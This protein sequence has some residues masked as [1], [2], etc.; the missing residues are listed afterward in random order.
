MGRADRDEADRSGSALLV[1]DMQPD[2]MAGGALAVEG[3]D[4]IVEPI[5]ALMES[6]TFGI[7]AA[8]QDWHPPGH[9]SFASTQPGR[10]PFDAI[11]LYGHEQTLWPDHC[12]QGTSGAELHPGLPWARVSVVV[13]KGM[14]P[15]CD[16]YS[17]FRNNWDENGGRPPT[18]LAGYLRERGIRDV[19]ICGV[20]RD[21]CCKWTA[22]DAVEAGF[23]VHFLWDLTRAVDPRQNG[24][25]RSELEARGVTILTGEIG[26]GRAS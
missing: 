22:V 3:A 14:D 24:A 10:K 26:N 8:T 6:E 18:G 12:V 16:S 5:R 23:R 17:G 13:R 20:A 11:G 19:A 4:R 7:C 1:V 15:R 25:V 9:V 2:F 21:F